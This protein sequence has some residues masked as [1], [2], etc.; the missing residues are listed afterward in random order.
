VPRERSGRS[1]SRLASRQRA[2]FLS[3]KIVNKNLKL[4]LIN[5]LAGKVDVLFH[6]SSRSHCTCNRIYGGTLCTYTP[7]WRGEGQ[8]YP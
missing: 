3:D 1:V 4:L 2:A 7:S 5:C 6:F 8:L